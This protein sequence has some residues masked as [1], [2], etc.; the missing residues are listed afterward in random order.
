[1]YNLE[2]LMMNNEASPPQETRLQSFIAHAGICSRRAAEK[3]ILEG[4]VR[5]NGALVTKLGTKVG[6]AD[7]VLVDGIP[8]H[9][10]TELHY[11]AMNKPPGYISSMSDPEGRPL[12]SRL[13]PAALPERLYNIG[14]LDFLSSGLLLWTNDGA[15]AAAAGHPRS[16]IEKEYLVEAT[17]II[18]DEAAIRF[19]EGIEIEGE[20]YKALGVERVNAK[21]L[22]VTLIEGK[23]REIRRVFSFFHLHPRILRRI[24][25]GPVRLGSLNEG[26]TRPLTREEIEDLF[27]ALRM[28]RTAGQEDA[29]RQAE[30]RAFLF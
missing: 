11:L 15:F 16:R 7:Q 8:I 22:L 17:G 24:R 3:L 13:L 2:R 26:Q 21:T 1:M 14:R 27:K 5:V 10:E 12:A 29:R 23:N 19:S 30:I 9:A 28:S 20:T 4:R 6:A 25:I 18:P